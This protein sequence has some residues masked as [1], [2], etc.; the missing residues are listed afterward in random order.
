[1]L[2]VVV[3]AGNDILKLTA[4]VLPAPGDR[5]HIGVLLQLAPLTVS[6]VGQPRT[7][8]QGMIYR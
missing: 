5:V 1:M 7:G 8:E 2:K 3:P 6:V 4:A